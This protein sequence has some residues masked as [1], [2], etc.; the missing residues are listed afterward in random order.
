MSAFLN[1]SPAQIS[2]LQLIR[3]MVSNLGY[4]RK[5]LDTRI[6]LNR[7]QIADRNIEMF[8]DP[9]R[10][11][12]KLKN[13]L[14]LNYLKAFTTFMETPDVVALDP[15]VIA[16]RTLTTPMYFAGRGPMG[17]ATRVCPPSAPMAQN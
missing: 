15:Q 3:L 4:S 1:A 9:S 10:K 17:N 2:T 14:P 13:S 7:K 16:Y 8:T 12:F 5:M 11:N 6:N